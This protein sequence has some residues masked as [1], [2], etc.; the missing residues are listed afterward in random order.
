MEPIKITIYS[1][2]ICPFCFLANNI[3]KRIQ[4]NYSVNVTWKPYELHPHGFSFPGI[5]PEYIK[6]AV[7]GKKG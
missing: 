3:V 4:K 2:Y 6:M 1:D 5:N 7:L